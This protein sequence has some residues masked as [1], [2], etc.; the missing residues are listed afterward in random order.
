MNRIVDAL[1]NGLVAI[2]A[3]GVAFRQFSPGVGPYGEPQLLSAVAARLNVTLPCDGG[4]CTKRAPDL[5]IPGHWAIEC[6]IARFFGDNG[7]LAENW[8]VNLLHPYPGNT[9]LL[10]DCLKLQSLPAKI[11]KAAVVIGYEHTPPQVSL[12][13]LLLSFELLARGVMGLRLAPRVQ[14]NRT[15]LVHPVH[16]QLTVAG[17][18]VL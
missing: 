9:S 13:P 2:D 5:L 1:A 7:K 18:E 17:W 16:Q 10:G 6:K 4:I 11:R 3:S 8:S 12:E 15:G 14:T